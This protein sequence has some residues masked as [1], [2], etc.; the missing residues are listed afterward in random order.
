MTWLA[1]SVGKAQLETG[2]SVS[3]EDSLARGQEELRRRFEARKT[4]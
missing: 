1:P 4:A 3:L 2:E